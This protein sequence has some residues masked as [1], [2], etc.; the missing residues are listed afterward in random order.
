MSEQGTVGPR[1]PATPTANQ[2]LRR[3]W[4]AHV[5][6]ATL[7]A[8]A[9]HALA[10][11]FSPTWT[12]RALDVAATGFEAQELILLGPMQ[13]LP[14]L[15]SELRR[16]VPATLIE[17]A[18]NEESGDA[19][20]G[21]DSGEA[22]RLDPW[23]ELNQR[24]RRRGPLVA[25]L[26]TLAANAAPGTVDAQVGRPSDADDEPDIAVEETLPDLALPEPDSLSLERLASVRPELAVMT[27]SAW[28][29]I[30]NQME[31]EAYLRR[32]YNDG[33]LDESVEGSV[34][35]T[36]WIDHQGSVEFAEVSE[37]SGRPDLD[38]FALALFNE[39]ADFR[40]ARER[41]TTVSRSVTF[42]LN[43]PW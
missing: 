21:D 15:A 31:V 10:F 38:E 18:G 35:V 11:A 30:R 34:S 14:V 4:D 3:R 39:V 24:L 26:A 2:R 6:W 7:T 27:T 25:S 20:L 28:V 36:L 16:P 12:A 5:G 37:S 33:L 40:A 19:G 17:T 29:L 9:L 8:A 23:G 43:F 13:G 32:S 41:G 42:S 1:D 22:E